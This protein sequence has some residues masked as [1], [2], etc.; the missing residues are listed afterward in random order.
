MEVFITKGYIMKFLVD[1]KKYCSMKG[2]IAI[3]GNIMEGKRNGRSS[4]WLVKEVAPWSY[5][6]RF[7]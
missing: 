5:Y 1:T 3:S 4:G 7:G 2:L 6:S